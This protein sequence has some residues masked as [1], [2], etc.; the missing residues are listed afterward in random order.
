MLSSSTKE[1]K[2]FLDKIY[3]EFKNTPIGR[4]QE[5]YWEQKRKECGIKRPL[6]T[7]EECWQDVT[8]WVAFDTRHPIVPSDSP[9]IFGMFK[10]DYTDYPIE[11]QMKLLTHMYVEAEKP[12]MNLRTFNAVLRKIYKAESKEFKNERTKAIMKEL[13]TLNIIECDEKG[14]EYIIVYRGINHKSAPA[15]I[16][17]SWTY[18]L[19]KAEWFANRFAWRHTDDRC[20]KVLQGKIYIKDILSI[21]HSRDEDE[22]ISFPHKVFDISELE[23]FVANYVCRC[24]TE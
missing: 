2:K 6:N 24:K 13:K 21:E 15:D 19:D 17:I 1:S 18:N 8:K 20:C 22:V 10:E 9:W 23:G 16:A 12:P 5:E 14:K 4:K 7:Y 11:F 3:S